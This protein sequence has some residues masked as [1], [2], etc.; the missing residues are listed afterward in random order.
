MKEHDLISIIVPIYNVEQYLE[1]CINSILN[2]TYTNLEIIL[3]D[4]GSPDN[5]G[6]ICDEYA[7]KDNRIKVIH[8]ENGGISSAR[9]T[10]LKV[11]R[12]AYVGFIDSDD[13][14]EKDMY[15][16]LYKNVKKENADISIC[17]NYD[18]Y[19]N[20]IIGTKKQGIYT[21]MTPEETIIKMNSF[22]Y[23]GFPVWNKLYKKELFYDLRF[24][25]DKKT[26]EDWYFLYEVICKC[27]KIVY[28]SVPKYYYC[29][30]E[31][32]L[33]QS[34]VDYEMLKASEYSIKIEKKK[35][36][37]ALPSV[38]TTYVFIRIKIYN[39]LLMCKNI[40]DR[41]IKMKQMR[42]EVKK[43]CKKIDK[44]ELNFVRNMQLK[45]IRFLPIVYNGLLI[46]YY[47]RK[48]L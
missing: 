34:N 13:Y 8:K 48:N 31:N 12:G 4:D 11:A 29:L 25:T 30:R 41:K 20:K 1:K 17:S 9:N 14:I 16:I 7:K 46:I 6:K 23:F 19:K 37:G 15:E 2:Q 35:Y 47:K 32:S 26:C 38:Y 45:L 24:L 21:V 43:N 28:Q 18:I 27:K 33:S 36:Q 39:Q 3:V 10:G 22:G 5:S 44:K 40:K 42:K